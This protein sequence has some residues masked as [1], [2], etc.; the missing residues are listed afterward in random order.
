V[1]TAGQSGRILGRAANY[2]WL[3]VGVLFQG[4]ELDALVAFDSMRPFDAVTR[5]ERVDLWHHR[6]ALACSAA[7]QGEKKKSLAA[8]QFPAHPR[9]PFP[10]PLLPQSFD[11]A[12]V[13]RS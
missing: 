2:L 1:G 6:E 5:V 7:R 9:A 8:I 11:L 4:R 12:R 3:L 10:P 13:C